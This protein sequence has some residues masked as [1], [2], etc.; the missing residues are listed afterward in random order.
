MYAGSIAE[1][2]RPAVEQ[3][4][5]RAPRRVRSHIKMGQVTAITF[6]LALGFALGLVFRGTENLGFL[7]WVMVVLAISAMAAGYYLRGMEF[8]GSEARP[9]PRSDERSNVISLASRR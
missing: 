9:S 6:A 3:P 5:S 7:E 2:R 8:G 4:S 1:V